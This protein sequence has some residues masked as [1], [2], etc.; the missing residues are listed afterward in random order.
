MYCSNGQLA[1]DAVIGK[2]MLDGCGIP[3]DAY[4]DAKMSERLDI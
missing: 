4:L 1:D 2:K 3:A